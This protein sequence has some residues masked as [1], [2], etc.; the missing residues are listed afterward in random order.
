MIS[1]VFYKHYNGINIDEHARFSGQRSQAHG[2]SMSK[3]AKIPLW[4]RG[5]SCD[6]LGTNLFSPNFHHFL[7][8]E[9][10]VNC[11]ITCWIQRVKCQDLDDCLEEYRDQHCVSS[12]SHLLDAISVG[13]LHCQLMA[14]TVS[15]VERTR[16]SSCGTR[17]SWKTL[18]IPAYCSRLIPAMAMKWSMPSVHVTAHSCVRA[19]LIKLFSCGMLQPAKSPASTEDMQVSV[20]VLYVGHV[21]CLCR[22]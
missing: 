2:Y 11:M 4:W 6:V 5:C 19:A 18:L 9:T 17:T 13:L 15:L 16:P 8:L 22:S 1:F 21:S 3:C 14:T 7:Q 12:S 20:R 10:K